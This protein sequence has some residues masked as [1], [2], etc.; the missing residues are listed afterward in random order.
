MTDQPV[1]AA[2]R[3]ALVTIL[4]RLERQE[5]DWGHLTPKALADLLIAAGIRLAPAPTAPAGL[6]E[7]L[8]DAFDAEAETCGG[9]AFSRKEGRA[10]V[11]TRFL[12]NV[13]AIASPSEEPGGVT[14][15]CPQIGVHDHPFRGPHTFTELYADAIAAPA[16]SGL[17]VAADDVR[18]AG[19]GGTSDYWRGF[20]DGIDKLVA[21]LRDEGASGTPAAI[22]P[23]KE[24][25]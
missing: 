19:G 16:S 14:T 7:A 3:D 23:D 13:A 1:P 18:F 22:P 25:S 2:E 12:A 11:V 15:Q 20:N 10:F 4:W 6:R 24:Q 8:D 9:N 5:G 17:D 21:R